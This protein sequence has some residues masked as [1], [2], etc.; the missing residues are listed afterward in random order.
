MGCFALPYQPNEWL[1]WRNTLMAASVYSR[2]SIS[3]SRECS[4]QNAH[5]HPAELI[6][7]SKSLEC[8]QSYLYLPPS[9]ARRAIFPRQASSVDA[10]PADQSACA[11]AEPD[12]ARLFEA[13][14]LTPVHLDR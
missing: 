13:N 1:I 4:S 10:F 3:I 9:E 14:P 8:D 2:D 12:S 6:H 5:R 7:V 11:P